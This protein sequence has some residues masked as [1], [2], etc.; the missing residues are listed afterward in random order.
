MSVLKAFNNHFMEFLWKCSE[1]QPDASF[2]RNFDLYFRT[3]PEP[4]H[5][6]Q[7]SE[8]MYFLG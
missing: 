6:W 3:E 7:K 8:I 2:S 1:M 4:F 5:K